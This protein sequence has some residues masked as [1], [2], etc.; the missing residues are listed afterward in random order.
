MD[1]LDRAGNLVARSEPPDKRWFEKMVIRDAF[2]AGTEIEGISFEDATLE[3]GDFT[4]AD[5]YGANLYGATLESCSFVNADLRWST[6]FE[7]CFHNCDMRGARFGISEIGGPTWVMQ[8][9]FSGSN[10]DGADFTGAVYD[11]QT[12]FPEDFD[13]AQRGLVHRDTVDLPR[14]QP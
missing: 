5:L 4:N 11:D 7:A 10:L 2:L 14:R 8:V 6:F 3:N 1:I 12:V 9:D 13:P